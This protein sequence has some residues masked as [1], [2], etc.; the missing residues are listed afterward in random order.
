VT[1]V[2]LDPAAVE[3]LEEAAD[4]LDEQR[5][6]LDIRFLAE[7]QRTL[8]RVSEN[9]RIGPEVGPGVHRLALYGFS[10]DVF[11]RIEEPGVVIFA[12]L[13][14]RRDPRHWQRRL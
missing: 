3:D 2:F 9:P 12:I 4:Y 13:H 14:Q 11:Y 1:P 7:V 5:P 8:R 10:D 6:G